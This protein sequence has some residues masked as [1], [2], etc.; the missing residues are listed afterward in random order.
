LEKNY[1]ME[2]PSISALVQDRRRGK[3]QTKKRK[4]IETGS[5]VKID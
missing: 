2:T 3:E 4:S 1:S 5:K